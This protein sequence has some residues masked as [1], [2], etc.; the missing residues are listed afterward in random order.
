MQK[1]LISKTL[2]FISI[3]ISTL[4]LP[5]LIIENYNLYFI[6]LSEN[7]ILYIYS[8]IAQVISSLIALTLIAVPYLFSLLEKNTQQDESWETSVLIAKEK[9]FEY[10]LMVFIIG[11]FSVVSCLIVIGA[12]NYPPYQD[13]SLTIATSS[14]IYFILI[15]FYLII[16]SFDPNRLSKI[17][18]EYIDKYIDNKNKS[19]TQTISPNGIDSLEVSEKL[20]TTNASHN[21]SSSIGDFFMEFSKL[22]DNINK[23][24]LQFSKS[25]KNPTFMQKVKELNHFGII[26]NN[27]YKQL[28][29]VRVFRNALAHTS[30]KMDLNQNLIKDLIEK[31]KCINQEIT[32]LFEEISTNISDSNNL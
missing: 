26:P 12:F 13:Y 21:F 32:K 5:V 17:N 19:N 9:V 10:L 31:I 11:I 3:S 22:E 6:T 7:S 25:I 27:L 28:N 29:E 16:Y 15:V 14:F 2:K 4:I 23:Y 30:H 18:D 20:E 1:N 8:T 24:Y